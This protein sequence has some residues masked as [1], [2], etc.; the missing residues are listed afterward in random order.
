VENLNSAGFGCG[1]INVGSLNNGSG[2]VGFGRDPLSLVSQLSIRRLPHAVQQR[3]E[4]HP[5]GLLFGSL[6]GADVLCCGAHRTLPFYYVRL[7][8]LTVGVRRLRIPESA[9]AL[10]PDGSGGV[11][12]DSGTAHTL[13]PGAVVAEVV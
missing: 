8:G 4:E 10:Q 2:I 13:L 11:I 9:F 3:E 7:T 6:T 12:V 5:P 1:S